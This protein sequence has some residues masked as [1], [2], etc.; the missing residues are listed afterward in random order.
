MLASRGWTD[1]RRPAVFYHSHDGIGILC[2]LIGDVDYMPNGPQ[3]SSR[4]D[5]GPLLRRA[6]IDHSML[7]VCL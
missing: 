7:E 3:H 6:G 4:L 2:P 5:A 1:I